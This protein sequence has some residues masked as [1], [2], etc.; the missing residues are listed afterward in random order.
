MANESTRPTKWADF[1][2][3]VAYGRAVVGRPIDAT[4]AEATVRARTAAR[5]TAF[6]TMLER[7]IF[8][9]A[10]SPYRPLLAAA[11]YDLPRLQTLVAERGLEPTLERLC[12]DGVYV[13]IEEF[14]GTCDVRRPGVTGRWEPAD[15]RNPTTTFGLRA[16][17]GGSRG[18]RRAT[19]I[20]PSNHR[21]GA[22]HLALALAAYRLERAP[23][24]VWLNYV[25]GA[26]L[27]ALLAL[28]AVR[29]PVPW[30]LSQL[31]AS[32]GDRPG[33]AAR[34]VGIRLGALSCGVRLP[35]P[36]HLAAGQ[37]ATLVD[38]L[39]RRGHPKRC[40][41]F[42]TPNCA[43]RVAL[44]ARR[45]ERRLEHVTFITIAEPLTA[46]KVAAIHAVGARAFS[47]LGFTE[48]GRVTYGCAAPERADD[49]HVCRDAIAVIRRR[50]A[51]D[52]FGTETDAL[53]FT[54]IQPDT[55]QVLL[56][57]ETGDYAESS[58]RACGCP[59]ARLGWHDQL[60]DI[61]SFEKLNAEGPPFPGSKLIQ[62]VEDVLPARFGGDPT[63]YQLVE[64]EDAAGVTRLSVLVHPRLGRIDEAAVAECVEHTLWAAY[65][66]A[67]SI[68]K[69]ARTVRIRRAP[70]MMT[71]AGKFLPLHHLRTDRDAVV[72]SGG[73]VGDVT[74][75][76]R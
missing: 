36:R 46:T 25:H 26:S 47:S 39:T 21:M 54:A 73:E 2:A 20:A 27:W 48:F 70:S 24:V 53:L 59:L 18:R 72:T 75:L 3:G 66:V 30:H 41:V 34:D 50:R 31:P 6:I 1:V 76:G 4:G 45:L 13:S 38:W 8:A 19:I 55:R 16:W 10:D 62:L 58:P 7:A 32:I 29:N 71:Q 42:T 65:G 57:V 23:V 15:F 52:R 63:D 9:N 17:T 37:E 22:E 64:E 74:A 35:R 43:L 67:T 33:L 56:N 5:G 11:G 12:R 61:R 68:W 60:R 28:A 69:N 49:A 44:A 51:V 14:K 40:G